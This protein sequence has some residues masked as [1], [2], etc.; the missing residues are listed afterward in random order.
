M[1]FN[2]QTQTKFYQKDLPNIA[3]IEKILKL[4]DSNPV[5]KQSIIRKNL[6]NHQALYQM[7]K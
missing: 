2:H 3:D 4:I 5:Q 1:T 7:L 6:E